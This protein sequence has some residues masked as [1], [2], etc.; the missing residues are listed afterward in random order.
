MSLPTPIYK[1]NAAQQ[2]SVYEPAEDTFLLLDAIEKDIQKLRDISPEIVLEIG[3]GSGVVSTFVNQV[4][5][6]HYFRV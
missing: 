1:L 4:C 2:Q 6:S 5:S 3:C